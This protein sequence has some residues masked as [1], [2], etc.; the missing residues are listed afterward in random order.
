MKTIL[1]NQGGR[2][3]LVRIGLKAEFESIYGVNFEGQNAFAA[4][5][6]ESSNEEQK[7]GFRAVC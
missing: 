3:Y 5:Q 4:Q 7:R 6:A 1:K 2:L